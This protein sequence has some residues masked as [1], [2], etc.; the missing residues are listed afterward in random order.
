MWKHPVFA[1]LAMALLVAAAH[2]PRWIIHDSKPYV[3]IPGAWPWLI[4]G[5]MACGVFGGWLFDWPKRRLWI[6]SLIGLPIF[7][8]AT[9]PLY[10]AWA[11]GML[12]RPHQNC[13]Q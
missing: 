11:F 10:F 6:A 9:A 4:G 5:W 13:S 12:K 3:E 2:L 7:L 1:W 8:A